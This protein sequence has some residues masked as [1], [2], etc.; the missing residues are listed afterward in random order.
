MTLRVLV[1]ESD[2]EELLFLEDV[3]I[4]IEQNRQWSAWVHVETIAASAWQE[5]STMLAHEAVDVI[6]LNPDLTDSQGANTFR[7]V[8]ER[9][10]HT[11]VIVLLDA[12]QSDLG[13]QLIREGAQDFLIKKQIDCAPLAQAMRNAI[14]RQRLLVAARATTMVDSLTGL[15][16][17]GA[18]LTF[19]ERDRSLAERLGRRL[20][21][22]VA[23]PKNVI[24]VAAAYGSQRRDL[25]LVEAADDLRGI[26]PST[27]LLAR[28]S[29]TRFALALV[30]S[31]A[32]PIESAWA[33]IHTATAEHGIAIGAAIFDA[34]KAVTLEAL[35]DRA[36][37]DLAPGGLAPQA[38]AMRR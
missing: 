1:V 20:L 18:F 2:P 14:E 29:A 15:L 28:I 7:R 25:T 34:S 31:A 6:L 12:E 33:H 13:T 37:A 27:A 22:V 9:T 16:N 35:L 10:A 23:E 30:D 24:E 32:E 21:L 11:P 38:L 17:R 4:E 19:A 8:Q 5:V 26:I 3:L 36:E